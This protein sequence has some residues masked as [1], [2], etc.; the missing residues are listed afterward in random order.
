MATIDPI[1][2]PTAPDAGPSVV[3]FVAGVPL[4]MVY[5]HPSGIVVEIVQDRRAGIPLEPGQ[6]FTVPAHIADAFEQD[7]GPRPGVAG[8]SPTAQVAGRIPGLRRV[9]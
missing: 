1:T 4:N 5:R 9:E 8:V 2:T 3:R 6:P 7:F